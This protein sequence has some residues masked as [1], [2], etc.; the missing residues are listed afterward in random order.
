MECLARYGSGAVGPLAALRSLRLT[1]GCSA[2]S[3]LRARRP[4]RKSQSRFGGP[5]VGGSD[6]DSKD[7]SRRWSGIMASGI[8]AQARIDLATESAWVVRELT[9]SAPMR[10]H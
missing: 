6:L 9:L 4:T 8:A 5:D 7:G 2:T 1:S 10:T 3:D